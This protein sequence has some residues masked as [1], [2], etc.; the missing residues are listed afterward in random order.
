MKVGRQIFGI[1]RAAGKPVD[2]AYIRSRCTLSDESIG[3]ALVRLKRGGWLNMEG[4]QFHAVYTVARDG[5]LPETRGSNPASRK[6]LSRGWYHKPKPDRHPRPVA[7]TALEQAWG[8][9]L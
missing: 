3:C 2:R 4:N 7:T 9:G 8:W 1:I 5:E 6:N